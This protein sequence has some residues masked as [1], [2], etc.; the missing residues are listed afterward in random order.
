MSVAG[1]DVQHLS[2]GLS[3][4]STRIDV[5]WWIATTPENVVTAKRTIAEIEKIKKERE[6]DTGGPDLSGGGWANDGD[7]PVDKARRLRED[8]ER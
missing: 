5:L 7:A 1:M 8:E 4:K 2:M 6:G 3:R